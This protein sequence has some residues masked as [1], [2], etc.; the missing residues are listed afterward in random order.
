M[1][2]DFHESEDMQ[3]LDGEEVW[4]RKHLQ[5]K[6]KALLIWS[7]LVKFILRSIFTQAFQYYYINLNSSNMGICV[8]ATV[9]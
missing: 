4:S 9:K 8:Y 6:H 3:K 7:I 1:E 2:E 5:R